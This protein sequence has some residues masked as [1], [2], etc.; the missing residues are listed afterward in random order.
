MPLDHLCRRAIAPR[1]AVTRNE[2]SHHR[3][4][5][6]AIDSLGHRGAPFEASR[7]PASRSIVGPFRAAIAAFRELLVV[8]LE[9]AIC[10]RRRV[11]LTPS[12]IGGHRMELEDVVLGNGHEITGKD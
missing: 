5:M 1:G 12:H 2:F 3:C 8:R 7:H 9:G 11:H 6:V 10:L 4:G